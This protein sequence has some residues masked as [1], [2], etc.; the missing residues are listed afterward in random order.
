MTQSAEI[1][2]ANTLRTEKGR[3][4]FFFVLKFKNVITSNMADTKTI[5]LLLI[6][7]EHNQAYLV[8]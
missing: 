2:G 8:M 7:D 4:E 1:Q 3:Q 5:G 6:L